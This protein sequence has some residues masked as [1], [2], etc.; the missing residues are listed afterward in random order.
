MES[1]RDWSLE[2]W[3]GL[4][5]CIGRVYWREALAAEVAP[6]GCGG[7]VRRAATGTGFLGEA[8]G[9]PRGACSPRVP[10]VPGSEGGFFRGSQFAFRSWLHAG[11]RPGFSSPS[12]PQ[13]LSVSLPVALALALGLGLLATCQ[14]PRTPVPGAA[15]PEA[16]SLSL[17]EEPPAPA[18][19]VLPGKVCRWARVGPG[20]GPTS[21]AAMGGAQAIPGRALPGPPR[22][23]VTPEA[24][25]LCAGPA[26]PGHGSCGP[27]QPL[28]TGLTTLPCTRPPS[29][30][31]SFPQA[32]VS[33]LRGPELLLQVRWGG[34][35][36]G[37]VLV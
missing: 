34:E 36:W 27:Q 11:G 19:P 22:G 31:P 24:M 3:S 7:R 6:G 5:P 4:C 18:E 25:G 23:P 8:G 20:S 37:A 2:H 12:G 15:S 29:V 16:A 26:R 17:R 9:L 1:L 33:S 28:E 30:P 35:E 10:G 14:D 13:F 21:W 32:P